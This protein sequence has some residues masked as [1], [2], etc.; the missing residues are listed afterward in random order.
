MHS[1]SET[2][3]KTESIHQICTENDWNFCY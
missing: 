1:S 2:K 3:P